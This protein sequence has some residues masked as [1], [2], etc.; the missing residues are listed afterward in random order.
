[1]PEL[2]APERALAGPD[3]SHWPNR[4]FGC[5]DATTLG[6]WAGTHRIISLSETWLALQPLLHPA[7]IT[8]V[9]DLTNLDELGIPTAQAVRPASRTYS[10]SHGQAPTY[11][12]AQVCAVMKS[13]E[14]WHVENLTVDLFFTSA[15][16]LASI[17]TYD[18]ARLRR[19][20][21]SLYHPGAKLDWV[22]A[23][24]LLTGQ[25]TWSPWE[26]VVVNAEVSDNWATPMFTGDT[27]GLA[28][29]NSY[30]EAALHG[31]YEVMERHSVAT[32]EP[33][34][35]MFEVSLADVA[36]SD[37]GHLIDKIYR[38][39]SALRIA[40]ID[41]W[42]GLYCFAT[43]VTSP[44]EQVPFSGFGFHHDPNVA[45]TQAIAEAAQTRLTAIA[46][47]GEDLSRAP[48]YVPARKSMRHLPTATPTRW[49]ARGTDSLPQLLAS[50]AAAV[51]ARTGTEPL[52]AVCDFPGG[53]VPVV[54][55]L[56]PGL[57]S[58]VTTFM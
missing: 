6:H 14:N 24:T 56:A 54:R 22:H 8:R 4:V 19:P 3:W 58:P 44:T 9:A 18:P 43:D 49:H 5:G 42:N 51:T 35:T 45:L 26:A 27:N 34:L 31:L 57:V 38:T 15:D 1:M 48:S 37:C 7:G 55:V 39:G 21:D 17:L 11:R 25:R 33:G 20:A 23:T 32:A 13:L 2:I 28:S 53:C 30:D 10:V 50:A 36:G 12:G 46:G 29:G 16:E 47:D 52:A 40:R 41:T